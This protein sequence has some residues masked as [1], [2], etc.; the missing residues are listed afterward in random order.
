LITPHFFRSQ[1]RFDQAVKLLTSRITLAPLFIDPA[2]L[3]AGHDRYPVDFSNVKGQE[4]TKRTLEIAA[5]GG[6]NL[7]TLFPFNPCLA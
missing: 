7:L 5:S 6:H 1:Q 3:F 2:E 4:H